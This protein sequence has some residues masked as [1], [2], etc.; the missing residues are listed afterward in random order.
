[1]DFGIAAAARERTEAGALVGTL[2]Y[3]PPER[4]AGRPEDARGDLYS[5][6]AVLY[7]VVCGVR[8]FDEAKDKASL[9][10]A[11]ASE[12]P[13]PPRARRPDLPPRLEAL[14]LSLLAKDP[15]DRP[16]SAQATVQALD[17]VLR[18]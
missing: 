17:A 3:L 2:A 8:P 5:L 11:V 13:I 10:A 15:A 4:A 1:V 9:L 14:I 7:E 16:A 12:A 6:G 18:S